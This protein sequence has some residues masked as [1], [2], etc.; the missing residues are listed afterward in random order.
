MNDPQMTPAERRA[1]LSLAAIFALRMLGLFMIL[2]VFA[3]YAEELPG[4]TPTLV[5]LAIGIYGLTQAALQ[6]P[7]GM[8]SDRIGRKP[9]IIGG[10]LVF[11]CGSVVAATAGDIHLIILGRAIQGAGAIAA[12]IMALAADLTREEHRVKAMG[13]IGVSIGMAFLAAMVLGPILGGL[14]GVPGI[15]WFTAVLALIGIGVVALVV[16]DPAHSS[17]HRDAEAVPALF[18]DVLRDPQLLRLDFGI[19]VLHMSLTAAFVAMPTALRDAGLDVGHH[20]LVYLPVMVLA[21]GAMVPFI[22]IAEKRRRLKPV[23]IGAIALLGLT[24]LALALW[25]QYL[26]VIAVLLFLYFTA[27]NL[28]E[29]SLPSLVAK[30][31]PTQAKGTAMGVYSSS[32]FIGAFIGGVIGGW[33]FGTYHYAGLYTLTGLLI[34]LWLA[35][36]V[37]MARPQHLATHML[38][39]GELSEAERDAITARLLGME[40]V[41]EAAINPEDGIAYLRVD[42]RTVD[43]AALD[44]LALPEPT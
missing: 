37:S 41:A 22:I 10:L 23:V 33:A 29:A 6:I 19:L 27:F 34:L 12:A 1:A 38:L 18:K 11:A 15:F 3:L 4:V 13:L 9:V 24:Q 20:W 8:L 39:V 28:L 35:A 36:A 16:P 21:M 32:Q 44:A 14:I 40:G 43:Y 30:F 26:W 25:H 2:P 17:V 5:G 7:F 31:A 42:S